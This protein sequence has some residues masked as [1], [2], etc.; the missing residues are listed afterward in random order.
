M[1]IARLIQYRNEA[2]VVGRESKSPGI[3]WYMVGF[4]LSNPRQTSS[5]P[6]TLI[7]T[8]RA[9]SLEIVNSAFEG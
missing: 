9:N 2:T 7:G 5:H 3:L 4:L 1:Y 8:A 6:K